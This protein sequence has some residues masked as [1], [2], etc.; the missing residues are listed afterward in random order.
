[1][2]IREGFGDRLRGERLRLGLTQKEMGAYGGVTQG[3]QR[4]YEG[5]R[6][7]PDISYLGKLERN[8]VDVMYALSGRREQENCLLEDEVK[9]LWQYRSLAL[10]LKSKIIQI[11]SVLRD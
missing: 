11:V 8:G 2:L 4:A 10:G 7:S 9:L 3:T 1:M 6:R 5:E